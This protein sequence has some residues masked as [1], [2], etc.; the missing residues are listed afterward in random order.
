VAV[1]AVSGEAYTAFD[2]RHRFTIDDPSFEFD[3]EAAHDS[4]LASFVLG[5]GVGVGI[6]IGIGIGNRHRHRHRHRQSASASAIGI[7]IGIGRWDV[8]DRD[9]GLG[10]DSGF[11]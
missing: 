6:G 4:R 10:V 5:V 1:R 7:G 2:G 3:A 11:G 9:L 8:G